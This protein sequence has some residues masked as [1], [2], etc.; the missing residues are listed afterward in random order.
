MRTRR[1][2]AVRTAVRWARLYLSLS[3]LALRWL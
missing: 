3:R 2:Y 1:Y